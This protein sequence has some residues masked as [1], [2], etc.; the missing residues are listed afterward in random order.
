M[1]PEALGRTSFSPVMAISSFGLS[2]VPPI[3][4]NGD[5][6]NV[7]VNLLDYD[8]LKTVPFKH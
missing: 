7:L 8:W 1:P 4:I 6:D 3:M 2:T 5:I